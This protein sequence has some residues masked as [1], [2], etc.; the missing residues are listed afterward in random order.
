MFA[1]ASL[2]ICRIAKNFGRKLH[3]IMRPKNVFMVAFTEWRLCCIFGKKTPWPRRYNV[4]LS[5]KRSTRLYLAILEHCS[6][7]SADKIDCP[8]DLTFLVKLLILVCIKSILICINAATVE[9][10]SIRAHSKSHSLLLLWPN[11]VPYA[12][13][14]SNK[15]FSTN[16]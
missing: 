1:L 8:R 6:C 4:A 16:L 3:T 2:V 15:P 9:D 13:F 5:Y 11:R 7:M 14:S 10:C 12:N